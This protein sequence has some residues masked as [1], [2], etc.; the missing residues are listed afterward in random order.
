MAKGVKIDFD[1]TIDF[2]EISAD[3]RIGTFRTVLD[4]GR[5]VAL[6]VEISNEEH[7]MIPNVFNLAFGPMDDKGR[8]DD[9]VQLTHQNYSAVFSTILFGGLSYLNENPGHYLGVDGSNNSR[10]YLY[11]RYLQQNY[12]YLSQY[13]DFFGIKYYVRISRFGKVQYE[14]PFDF[15]DILPSPDRIQKTLQWPNQMYNYFIFRLKD[16]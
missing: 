1:Q 2:E 3:L 9:K 13:F 8:I 11:W 6:K 16:A 5:T 12:D 4:D 7:E 14:N 10:A 15:E